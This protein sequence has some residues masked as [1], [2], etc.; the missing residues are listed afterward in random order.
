MKRARIAIP[1]E[2]KYTGTRYVVCCPFCGTFLVGGF[3]KNVLLY[4]C[5]QCDNTIKID[6]DKMKSRQTK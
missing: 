2:E 6:W 3:S 1:T 5:S 4:K